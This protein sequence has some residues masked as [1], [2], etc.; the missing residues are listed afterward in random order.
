MVN[1]I[2]VKNG[3]KRPLFVQKWSKSV[4][5]RTRFAHPEPLIPLQ[6][7]PELPETAAPLFAINTGYW[8]VS[9]VISGVVLAVW[10]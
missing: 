6:A 8:Q 1:K 10:R 9:L 5:F 3:A 7:M 4:R 2:N